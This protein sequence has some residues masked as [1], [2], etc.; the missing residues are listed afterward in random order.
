MEPDH[1]E[2]KGS[3]RPLNHQFHLPNLGRFFHQG[4]DS[5]WKSQGFNPP[6]AVWMYEIPYEFIGRKLR[7]PHLVGAG[8]NEPSTVF[9]LIFFAKVFLV[10]NIWG[11]EI[12]SWAS[13]FFWHFFSKEPQCFEGSVNQS[14]S[15]YSQNEG[16]AWALV[17]P[18][19]NEDKPRSQCFPAVLP[20]NLPRFMNQLLPYPSYISYNFSKVHPQRSCP[21]HQ[22]TQVH[23]KIHPKQSELVISPNNGLQRCLSRVIVL[24][25]LVKPE[26]KKGTSDIWEPF[27]QRM[28]SEMLHD[29]MAEI[30]LMWDIFG[31]YNQSK[32]KSPEIPP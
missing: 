12:V 16:S 6:R 28:V 4:V 2:N 22:L 32:V 31:M 27:C 25:S 17:P 5:G 8:K 10:Q 30:I 18:K 1:R 23:Q 21:I 13:N 20:T 15:R 24:D 19:P 29:D 3:Q 14:S 11:S 9:C 7:N 26:W